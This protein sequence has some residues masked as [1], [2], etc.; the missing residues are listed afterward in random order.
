M[1]E[2]FNFESI[3][4]FFLSATGMQYVFLSTSI[5]FPVFS[6]IVTVL[7]LKS[8]NQTKAGRSF[9]LFTIPICL[10]AVCY[11]VT[12]LCCFW[13]APNYLHSDRFTD[14][15]ISLFR[16]NL[17]PFLIP[18]VISIVVNIVFNQLGSNELKTSKLWT[19]ILIS[20][21]IVIIVIPSNVGFFF[22]SFRINNSIGEK[23][24]LPMADLVAALNSQIEENNYSLFVNT[25]YFYGIPASKYFPSQITDQE[26]QSTSERQV[27]KNNP[28]TFEELITAILYY[29]WQDESYEYLERAI[30]MFDSGNQSR[31]SKSDIATFWHI[32]GDYAVDLL[33]KAYYY[34][35]AVSV[36]LELLQSN[37]YWQI[38]IDMILG[39]IKDMVFSEYSRVK[40]SKYNADSLE[41]IMENSIFIMTYSGN[42]IQT[43]TLLGT[44]CLYTNKYLDECIGFLLT[45]DS[46]C[47]VTHPLTK[48]L[49]ANLLLKTGGDHEQ[50]LLEIDNHSDFDYVENIYIS[51]YW[52]ER[53]MYENIFSYATNISNESPLYILEYKNLLMASWYINNTSPQ[54]IDHQTVE[55]TF[56]GLQQFIDTS[57]DSETMLLLDSYIGYTSGKYNYKEFI[58]AVAPLNESD[59]V[60]FIIAINAYNEGD[61]ITSFESCDQILSQLDMSRVLDEFFV[62]L[63]KADAHFQYSRSFDMESAERESHLLIAERECLYFEK[64]S[65]FF[66]YMY[67]GYSAFKGTPI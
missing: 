8:S 13:W 10:F 54:R 47:A 3:K 25:N 37:S 14:V 32:R 58:E 48:I 29:Y 1:A 12:I 59:E 6:T 41:M 61:Y 5:L 66:I 21:L 27:P 45:V 49:L 18:L 20:V 7:I 26:N 36:Y 28:K 33:D 4:E 43:S 46:L 11:F 35:E 22:S 42:D 60:L 31:F 65:K 56:S 16:E 62:R 64:N 50:Q 67:N 39:K 30:E 52:L 15:L 23:Y 9:T 51:Q 63:I 40:N 2:L 44:V 24:E 19:R 38:G 53:K 34:R 57:G 17:I 55:A